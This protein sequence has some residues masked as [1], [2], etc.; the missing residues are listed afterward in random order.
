MTN[1]TSGRRRWDVFLSHASEDNADVIHPLTEMLLDAG[2]RVWVDHKE[3]QIGDR[4][5][6]RISEGLRLSR[7]GVVVFSPSFF[8]KQ[9]TEAELEG[10]FQLDQQGASTI[11][12]VWHEIGLEDVRSHSPMLAGRLAVTTTS[13]VASVAA[14]LYDRITDARGARK[15]ALRKR[16]LDV[17]RS[18]EALGSDAVLSIA[19]VAKLTGAR[20]P[21]IRRW[22]R[23]RWIGINEAQSQFDVKETL[24]ISVLNH[25]TA[26]MPRKDL[27]P[28][29]PGTL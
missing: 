8:G 7:F 21:Q 2:L 15:A 27:H 23:D 1:S 18:R 5:L 24:A 10:L 20:P 16:M 17:Q 14:A 25:W 29:I 11:L 9:W 28:R 13:G 12:P 22:V 6:Q 3:L 19:Q 4:L 26:V